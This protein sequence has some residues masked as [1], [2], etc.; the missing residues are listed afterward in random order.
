MVSENLS[1]GVQLR[2]RPHLDPHDGGNVQDANISEMTRGGDD[3][4]MCVSFLLLL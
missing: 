2:Q 4:S 3:P 1:K